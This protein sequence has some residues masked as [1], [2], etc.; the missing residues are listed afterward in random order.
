ML[1]HSRIILRA[2][3]NCISLLITSSTTKSSAALQYSQGRAAA[4]AAGVLTQ[5]AGFLQL[6]SLMSCNA[7]ACTSQAED[8]VA[9]LIMNFSHTRALHPKRCLARSKGDAPRRA[10]LCISP[11][12]SKAANSQ[13][14]RLCQ[15]WSHRPKGQKPWGQ[16]DRDTHTH[17]RADDNKCLVS[18]EKLERSRSLPGNS[19]DVRNVVI[20]LL[21]WFSSCC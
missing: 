14:P 16:K 2:V 20:A 4:A 6:F 10:L 5:Q 15:T 7:Q 12:F 17:A 3:I 13:P 21:A 1:F 8:L 11:A 18:L 19:V 9:A